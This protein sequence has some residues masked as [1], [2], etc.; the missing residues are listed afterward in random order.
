MEEDER[1]IL[2]DDDKV[3]FVDV[4]Q[5]SDIEEYAQND[6]KKELIDDWV[7][8]WRDNG[9]FY[10]I[11]DKRYP[12]NTHYLYR[13]KRGDTTYWNEYFDEVT[14][15]EFVDSL[16]HYRMN[17]AAEYVKENLASYGDTYQLL[18]DILNKKTYSRY[19][20][21]S[22]VDELIYN[23]KISERIPKNSVIQLHF[24]DEEEFCNLF[25]DELNEDDK[26][27][28]KIIFNSYDGY[29]FKDSYSTDDDWREGYLLR[30]FNDVNIAK[31]REI[32]KYVNPSLVN[33]DTNSDD[34]CS[35]VA[36]FLDSVN[37]DYSD[38]IGY[39][40]TSQFN[41]AGNKYA[42]DEITKDLCNVLTRVKFI[43]KYCLSDYLTSVG[44]LKLLYDKFGDYSLTIMELLTLV[45][46]N[47]KLS[48]GG[49][50][51]YAYE[52]G[53]NNFDDETYNNEVSQT[54][55]K[56]LN[57]VSENFN[58]ETLEIYDKII[59][60]YGMNQFH[61]IP[62]S[63]GES[64]KIVRIDDDDKIVIKK[65]KT[66]DLY[67]PSQEES[68]TLEEFESFLHNYK[69]FESK[70]IKNIIREQ[71]ENVENK[72]VFNFLKELPPITEKK[73]L[74]YL[75]DEIEKYNKRSSEPKISL[76]DVVKVAKSPSENFPFKLNLNGVQMG[77][78]QKIISTAS[79]QATPKYEFT[80][81]VNPLWKN[82]LPGVNIKLKK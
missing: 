14:Y 41:I 68:Y 29:E 3:L 11:V 73:P 31:I 71:L 57:Y 18:L 74:D 53:Y 34:E 60:K 17:S 59:S 56:F 75:K 61:E 66:N 27:F 25:G 35:E 13:D 49:Y 37:S 36:K 72:E 30:G 22:D 77:D 46:S 78:E 80:L 32:L 48:I 81:T 64:F 69:L 23:I 58:E 44:H 79:Y 47:L 5:A 52:Y 33:F 7:R 8:S 38:E 76:K 67:G 24:E 39:E 10:I 2:I 20:D 65:A 42:K 26:W 70:R 55:D 82:I 16:N 45:V 12:G 54:L 15:R 62:S 51:E 4:Q 1:K 19:H 43:T 40:Y 50:Y 28:I 9:D 6:I 63:E 21:F